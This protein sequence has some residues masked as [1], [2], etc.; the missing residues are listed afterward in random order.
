MEM[1]LIS[2]SPLVVALLTQGVKKIKMV[3]LSTSGF[4]RKILRVAVAFLSYGAIVGASML[5]GGEVDPLA[6]ETFAMTL[7]TF[8]G[9]TGVYFFAKK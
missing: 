8:F 4:K 2:L 9:S 6:T 5:T 7:M 3:K 1:L